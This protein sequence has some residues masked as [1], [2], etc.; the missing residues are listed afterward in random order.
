MARLMT[1]QEASTEYGQKVW[2]WRTRVWRGD[3]PNVGTDKKHLLDRRDI[4]AFIAGKK[5]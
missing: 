4:E 3:L 5:G 2:W 1:Y